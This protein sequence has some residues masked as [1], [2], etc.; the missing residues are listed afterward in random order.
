MNLEETEKEKILKNEAKEK[1]RRGQ[2]SRKKF[3]WRVLD[4]RI[5]KWY[6]HEKEEEMEPEG[7]V[8]NI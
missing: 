7:V 2:R 1:T 6:I 3:F 8:A 4:V 5:R